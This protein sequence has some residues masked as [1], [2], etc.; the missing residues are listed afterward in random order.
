[1]NTQGISRKVLTLVISTS[2]NNQTNSDSTLHKRFS[3]LHNHVTIPSNTSIKL[4]K[5]TQVNITRLQS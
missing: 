1:M 5:P 2:A 4:Y 3:N